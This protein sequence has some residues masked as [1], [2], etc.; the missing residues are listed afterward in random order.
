MF[1]IFSMKCLKSRQTNANFI[2][3]CSTDQTIPH[4]AYR[5]YFTFT[6][7][8]S[9]QNCD[10]NFKTE[11]SLR[12]TFNKIADAAAFQLAIQQLRNSIELNQQSEFNGSADPHSFNSE[13]QRQDFTANHTVM[14]QLAHFE[15]KQPIQQFKNRIK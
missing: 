6:V 2:H 13:L 8:R 11:V 14:E 15:I 12:C 3:A 9:L 1:Q 7:V 5:S 4:P 10:L